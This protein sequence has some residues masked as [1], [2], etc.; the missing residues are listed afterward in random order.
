MTTCHRRLICTYIINHYT[1]MRYLL[2]RKWHVFCVI[3][4]K[5]FQKNLLNIPGLLNIYLVSKRIEGGNMRQSQA[6]R[7][8]NNKHNHKLCNHILRYLRRHPR[9][10]DTIEGI[11]T[12]WLEYERVEESVDE[13][14]NALEY[15]V[16][17]GKLKR[18]N[19]G[20]RIIFKSIER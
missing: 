10:G 7:K 19:T 8:N 11:S 9:S 18:I 17:T 13:V 1:I 16:L 6:L 2:Y 20:R 4:E 12:W 15:L 14:R 5:C 3:I